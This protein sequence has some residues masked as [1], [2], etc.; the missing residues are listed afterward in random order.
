MFKYDLNIY[1][2]HNQLSGNNI[3]LNGSHRTA[4]SI[5]FDK[6]LLIDNK[7][8]KNPFMCQ[9]QYFFNR[10]KFKYVLPDPGKD[11]IN[12]VKNEYLDFSILEYIRLKRNNIRKS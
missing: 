7:N 3:I 8:I 12:S 6:Q 1:T 10:N 2:I 11:V 9:S 4:C 5:F